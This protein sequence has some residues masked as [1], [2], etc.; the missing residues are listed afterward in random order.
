VL[1]GP[2]NKRVMLQIRPRDA[3]PRPLARTR[4]FD[5]VWLPSGGEGP[6]QHRLVKALVELIRS[7]E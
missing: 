4:R 7:N 6:E 1:E 3:E 2:G 5:L